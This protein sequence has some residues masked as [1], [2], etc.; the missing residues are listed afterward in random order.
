MYGLDLLHAELPGNEMAACEILT[1][2]A[3][4]NYDNALKL[5]NEAQTTI[6]AHKASETE[7]FVKNNCFIYAAFFELLI[8][9]ASYWKLVE[10][11]NYHNSWCKLQDALD[12]LR[13]LKRFYK[14]DSVT[15]SYLTRQLLS[16]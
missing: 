13:Q 8:S 5:A 12:C 10:S 2:I 4:R 1:H 16:I 9:L 14:E 7:D 6:D 15:L 3:A 11:E